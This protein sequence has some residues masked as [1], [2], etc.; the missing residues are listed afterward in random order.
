MALIKDYFLK[1]EELKN[2][3]G[4][5]SVRLLYLERIKIFFILGNKVLIFNQSFFKKILHYK[6]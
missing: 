4:D 2:K 6:G 5:K 3:Y 1:T